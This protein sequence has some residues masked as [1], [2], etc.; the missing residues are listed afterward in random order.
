MTS[1]A[2]ITALER[3]LRA[4]ASE[5][6][7]GRASYDLRERLK[8]GAWIY[9]AG[10]YGRKIRNLLQKAGF[11]FHGFV[12][13]RAGLEGFAHEIDGAARAREAFR[14]AQDAALVIGI[15]NF[16][17][18][19]TEVIEWAESVGFSAVIG[20][21]ELPDLLGAE[22]GSYWLT[23][24]LHAAEHV[25]EFVALARE[26]AD[27]KSVE[28]IRCLARMRLTGDSRLQPQPDR[29][30]QYLPKDLDGP[31]EP[32]CL[33]DGGAFD[34]DTFRALKAASLSVSDWIAF[35]PDLTNF[36]KLV[37]TARVA[38]QT[39]AR[40]FPCGLGARTEDLFFSDGE[41]AG[42]HITT[43]IDASGHIRVV[44]L[45][46]VAP[47]LIP[48]FV[49]LDVEGAEADALMGMKDILTASRPS[50]AISIYHKPSDLW[51]LPKLM[52]KLMGAAD[53]HI[54]QH[55]YN[56]FDT[57]LYVRPR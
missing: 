44:A 55:G 22:A 38:S 18:D 15:H 45:D 11:D 1:E 34:G 4:L 5:V 7:E 52:G 31:R 54:R 37:S 9:G 12:D 8:K 2:S 32:I 24:R 56:G 27:A 41:G 42:S 53:F 20:P 36:S 13:R 25:D 10:G 33:V 14:G 6:L 19:L 3:E 49:K 48:T 21:G 17:D 29:D 30:N 35:E 39:R 16:A 28:V 23:S 47:D 26:V 43:S 50:C 51:E 46:E 40:L 57:V